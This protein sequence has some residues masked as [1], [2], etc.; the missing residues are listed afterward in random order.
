MTDMAF[1]IPAPT[2]GEEPYQTPDEIMYSMEGYTQKGATFLAGA[3]V[4]PGGTVVGRIT[5]SKKWTVYDNG[6]GDGTEVARGILR[7]TIDTTAGDVQANMVVAGL[8]KNSKVSGADAAAITDLN[9]RVDTVLDIF[10][11]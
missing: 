2:Y 9:A 4:L 11:F 3:G 1:N 7:H 8:V 6:A 5:A 10:R